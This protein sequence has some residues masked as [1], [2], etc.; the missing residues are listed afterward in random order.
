MHQHIQQYLDDVEASKAKGTF[1]TRQS[2][3][4]VFNE[5]L[6]E[7]DMGPTEVEA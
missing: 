5:F 1:Q 6:A 7:E 2:D 4:R 3:L